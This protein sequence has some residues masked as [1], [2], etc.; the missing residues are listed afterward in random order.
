MQTSNDSAKQT[1]LKLPI[2]VTITTVFAVFTALSISLVTSLS[3]FSGRDIILESAKEDIT[4]S[5][6]AAQKTIADLVGQAA[7]TAETVAGMS[8][9]LFDWKA[10]DALLNALTMGLRNN[11]ELYGVF[12]GFDDGAFVQGI[13]LVGSDGAGRKVDGMPDSA[14]MA[15]RVIGPVIGPVIDPVPEGGRRTAHWRYFDRAGVELQ[16]AEFNAVEPSGYDPRTRPWFLK[17]KREGT[18]VISD[19]YV[20]ASLKKPGMTVSRTVRTMPNAVVGVDLSLSDLAGLARRLQPGANG[21]FAIVDDKTRLVAYSGK[22]DVL[23]PHASGKGI[24]LTT[25]GELNDARLTQAARAAGEAKTAGFPFK[26]GGADYLGFERVPPKGSLVQWK[27][28]SAAAVDDYIGGLMSALYHSLGLAVVIVFVSVGVVAVMGGWISR[29]VVRLRHVADQITRLN[30][31][32]VETF[33]SPFDEIKMLQSS[34]ERMRSALDMFLRFVPRD[35]VRELIRGDRM[36]EVGGVRR[37]VTLLFTDVEGFTT[38]T[39]RMTPEQIMSQASEYFE[40]M[41]FGIQ[42][43]M[44]TIDKFIGDAIMAMWNAP[45]E[46]PLHV[47]NACRAA[48]TAYH[49]SEDLNAEFTAAGK[50]VMRT[51]FGLHT[52]DVLVGNLGARDRMQYTCLGSGVNLAA[53]LE[54][55]NKFYGTSILASGMVRRK[56]SPAYLFRRV[57]IVEAKGTTIP[58]TIF[59]LLGERDEGAAFFVGADVL[60][61]A[62]KYEQAFDFYLHRDFDD[63]LKLLDDLAVEVPDDPVVALL[64]K[65]CKDYITEPPPPGWNGATQLDKK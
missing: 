22:A 30:L 38:M 12:V 7:M 49:I 42:A 18:T 32:Q 36:A 4:K 52:A 62:G 21:L 56:A 40:R 20:F 51:R 13:N 60:R 19:A 47:D 25:I 50:P 43:N 58:V 34:M 8:P 5:A 61:R 24:D 48:L 23:K 27:L 64:A 31:S 3:F 41:S 44:G 9:H 11:R 15:W 53:R 2:R 45:T 16:G 55:L 29:P 1:R 63:A 14:A 37:E 39:E 57:D 17:A 33:D 59:E 26:V 35:V 6:E 28:I 10:P 65:K 54:G 46:D